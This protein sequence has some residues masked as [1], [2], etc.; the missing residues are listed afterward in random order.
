MKIIRN[1]EVSISSWQNLIELNK[2]SSPFQ[3]PEYFDFFNNVDDFSADVFAVTDDH[4][5]IDSL[6]V[7]TIQQEKGLKA[8]F[9]KRGIIYGGPLLTSNS[10]AEK[11]FQYI[12]EYYKQKLIYIETRNF[13]D[14]SEYKILLGK[15]G[16]SYTPWLNFQLQTENPT[17]IKKNMSSSRW[18]Q[19]KKGIKN[20][21]EIKEAQSED[22]VIAFYEI[23]LE[24][25]K[26][27]IKKPLLPKSFFKAFYNQSLGKY[28]LIFYEGKVIGGIMCPILSGKAIYEFYI[29]GLD[30]KFRDQNPSILAT[31]AAIDYAKENSLKYFD[32]MGAGSPKEEYG[33]RDFKSRFGGNEVEHGRFIYILN[34]PKYKIG[35]LGLKVLSKLK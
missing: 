31:W 19:V 13:F 33:V 34:K 16:W 21:A 15:A 6:V 8:G 4:G 7:L 14:Y 2:F 24:L 32:F 5:E 25:Y 11:L 23:L 9:S 30:H 27:K 10:G 28:L 29:C 22:D 26:T 18:R 35:K 3:T 1:K 12:I 20:G 17:A